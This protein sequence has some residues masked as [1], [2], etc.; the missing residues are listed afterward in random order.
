MFTERIEV[1]V[2]SISPL[3]RKVVLVNIFCREIVILHEKPD[4][5]D[6]SFVNLMN[7]LKL[8]SE[9]NMQDLE[10]SLSM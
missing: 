5:Q 3:K 1:T 9:N 7:Q 4:E 6:I 8:L 2:E 10:E